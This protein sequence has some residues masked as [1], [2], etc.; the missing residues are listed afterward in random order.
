LSSSSSLLSISGMSINLTSC[1]SDCYLVLIFVAVK[2]RVLSDA[3]D[4]ERTQHRDHLCHRK[5]CLKTS[6]ERNYRP[7]VQDLLKYHRFGGWAIPWLVAFPGLSRTV[8]EGL[9]GMLRPHGMRSINLALAR[10]YHARYINDR[11]HRRILK[12][13]TE[14]RLRDPGEI[15]A[16]RLEAMRPRE[17]ERKD[18]NRIG[19]LNLTAL[20]SMTRR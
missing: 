19:L 14:G 2:D 6:P 8:I 18:R 17:N 12:V 5:R 15:G 9:G 20:R 11:A 1:L 16:S 3:R 4:P 7:E 13:H 10:L